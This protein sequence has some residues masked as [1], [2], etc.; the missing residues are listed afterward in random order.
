MGF[1]TKLLGPDERPVLLLRPHAKALIVPALVLLVTAPVTAYLA[2]LVPDG[3]AQVWMRLALV[4]AALAVIGRWTLWPFLV[5]WNTIYAITDRRLVLRSGV[6]N[7][8]GHDMPL[9]R[10]N[11]VKF[12]H[13]VI[14]RVL[15][16]G[17]LVVESAGEAGQLVLDDVPRVEQVQRALYR[18]SDQIRGLDDPGEDDLAED[19]VAEDDLAARADRGSHRDDRVDRGDRDERATQVLDRRHRNPM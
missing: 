7:R 19:D 18:L 3:S 1:P 4:V 6:L 5:W 16:C 15:G 17:T 12:S 14:E 10:L 9:T 8:T 13:T 2:G 11:D